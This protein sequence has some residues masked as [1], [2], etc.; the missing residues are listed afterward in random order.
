MILLSELLTG[1]EAGPQV[2]LDQLMIECDGTANKGR[3]GANAILGVSLA[4]AKA[5]AEDAGFAVAT[6][7]GQIK[8]GSL[9]R[10]YR[11]IE[12]QLGPAAE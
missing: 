5:A 12:E 2:E 1:F 10:S 3:L 11:L 7:C 4:I 8:T 6:N 9:S